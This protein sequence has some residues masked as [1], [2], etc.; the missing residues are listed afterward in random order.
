MESKSQVRL[1]QNNHKLSSFWFGFLLGGAVTGSTAFFL[2]TKQGRK[3]LK[4]ILELTEN[5]EETLETFFEEYGEEIKEKG[6]ELLEDIKKQ[7]KTQANNSFPHS[8]LHGILDKI[9]IF[10]PNA[11]KKV[12]RFFMKEGKIVEKSS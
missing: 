9:K 10:S 5:M 2:G 12:K 6:I 7:P 4:K 3:T 8:T 11:Q 1:D